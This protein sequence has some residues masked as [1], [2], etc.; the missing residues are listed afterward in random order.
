M[1]PLP[2]LL[3]SLLL[4][5]LA[6]AQ[7]QPSPADK[8]E[9]IA[10]MDLKAEGVSQ[11]TANVLSNKLRTEL[12]NSGK[13]NV[14]NREDMKAILG[15]QEFQQ[16][17]M[18]DDMK[19][20]AKIGGALG[21]IYMV[22]GSIGKLG[23]TYNITLKMIDIE[24]IVNVNIIDEPY[25]G[26]DDGLFIAIQ[27]AGRK[28]MG[29]TDLLPYPQASK[30]QN[31]QQYTIQKKIEVAEPVDEGQNNYNRFSI[32]RT[33]TGQ[34]RQNGVVFSRG[35]FAGNLERRVRECPEA[36]RFVSLG[37]SQRGGGLPLGL[38]MI[39]GGTFFYVKSILQLIHDE[40][41]T[42][43]AVIYFSAAMGLAI[44]GGFTMTLGGANFSR[45]VAAYNNCLK[46]KYLSPPPAADANKTGSA[47]IPGPVKELYEKAVACI[48]NGQFIEAVDYSSRAIAMAP[49]FTKAYKSRGFAYLRLK[50]TVRASQ[51]LNKYLAMDNNS[52]NDFDQVRTTLKSIGATPVK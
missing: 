24:K 46:Q 21:V 34:L 13:Y 19:C 6:P 4:F 23:E 11:S 50:D 45:A 27:N 3:L 43:Q 14:L 41:I 10:V 40:N 35:Y 2:V 26:A 18:C 44:P 25:S 32:A 31:T 15:E 38:L 39:T 30:P 16:S 37:K 42:S 29:R 8:K 1:R 48:K 33:A 7:D 36:M 51:D 12:F 9:P 49:T 5:D 28:L 17:G 22:T 52:D 47:A 20:M